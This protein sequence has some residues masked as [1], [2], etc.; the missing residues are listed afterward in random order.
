MNPNEAGT[1]AS[2]LEN[3]NRNHCQGGGGGVNESL[4]DQE[5]EVDRREAAFG[6]RAVGNQCR[7]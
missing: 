6:K 4:S 7:D 2:N 3:S 5:N 1:M